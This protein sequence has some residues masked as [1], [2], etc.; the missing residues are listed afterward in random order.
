M[1][2]STPESTLTEMIEI[3]QRYGY[4][5]IEPR[6][7]AGHAHGIEVS[8]DG[9]QRREIV[10]KMDAASVQLGC[11]ATSLK[12]ADYS[13]EE[14]VR[15]ESYER[16]DL[17]ADLKVPVLR[18]FGGK[19]PEDVSRED[20]VDHAARLLTSIAPY[21][22][23]RGVRLCIETHDDWCD[24]AHVVAILR[25]VDHTAIG[26]NWDI[27]H[28]VRVCGYTMDEAFELL[29]DW[30]GHVHVHDGIGPDQAK[31]VAIGTGDIDRM[32]PIG[33]GGI[34]HRRALELLQKI[35]Y[36]GFISGEWIRWEAWD[37]HLPREIATLRRFEAEL[38]KRNRT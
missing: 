5:G 32:L 23:E 31:F 13:P 6:L 34:D 33:T 18:V 25:R 26:V 36:S 1:S 2:F 7:D 4:D 27:M 38:N 28:P 21:A 11:L 20:A 14:D 30:I 15:R 37:I 3:A 12:Y 19:I 24:P 29:K 22:A 17:A 35:E 9:E 10:A 8:I 16:I